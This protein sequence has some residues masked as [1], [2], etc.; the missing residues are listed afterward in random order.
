MGY[1]LSQTIIVLGARGEL[2]KLTEFAKNSEKM[3][4]MGARSFKVI[5]FDTNRTS[6]Y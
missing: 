4:C 3:R 5:E 1:I 6:S 2:R